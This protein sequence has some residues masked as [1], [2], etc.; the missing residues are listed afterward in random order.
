MRLTQATLALLLTLVA[1]ALSAQSSGPPSL[2]DDFVRRILVEALDHM[3]RA[4]CENAQPCAPATAAEKENPPITVAEARAIMN[5]GILSGAAERCGLDW[6]RQ[7][8]TPMMAYWR[9]DMRKSERQM[10]LVAS[11]HG[12][13]QGIVNARADER[14]CTAQLRQNLEQG[15][16]FRP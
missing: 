1:T 4:R 16:P 7:N 8:F 6:Q 2:S 13:M 5:R 12:I 10:A 3:P 11:L 15:L 9:K 14:G